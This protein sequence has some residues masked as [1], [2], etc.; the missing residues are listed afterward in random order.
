MRST[1]NPTERTLTFIEDI[2]GGGVRCECPNC[3]HEVDIKSNTN[4]IEN[5]PYCENEMKYP[6]WASW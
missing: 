1:S 5:C 3:D 4:E 2:K 6:A